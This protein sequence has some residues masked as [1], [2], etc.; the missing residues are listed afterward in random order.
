MFETEYQWLRQTLIYLFLLNANVNIQIF[1]HLHSLL[2][3]CYDIEMF[4]RHFKLE[5]LD[6]FEGC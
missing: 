5:M 6:I 3:D 2:C 4:E 1:Y